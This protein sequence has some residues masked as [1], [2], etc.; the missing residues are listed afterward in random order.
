MAQ[1]KSHWKAGKLRFYDAPMFVSCIKQTAAV[2]ASGTQ[3]TSSALPILQGPWY[4]DSFS[5]DQGMHFH[6]S[7]GGV[8]SAGTQIMSVSLRYGT[9]KVVTVRGN[10]DAIDISST[11]VP[12]GGTFDGR[13]ATYSTLSKVSAK[14]EWSARWQ[15]TLTTGKRDLLQP[16]RDGTTGGSSHYGTTDVNLKA[17]STIGWNIIITAN[18]TVGAPKPYYAIN[19]AY[20][21]FFD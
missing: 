20:M 2:T 5:T 7:W 17:A 4:A 12:W 10:T 15:N 3:I 13:I 14:G 19:H 18:T 8:I 21:Q 9:A 6:A 16:N 1:T 11:K